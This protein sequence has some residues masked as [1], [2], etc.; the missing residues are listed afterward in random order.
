[1]NLR[2]AL[3]ILAATSIIFGA[4]FHVSA[5]AEKQTD[6]SVMNLIHKLPDVGRLPESCRVP[7]G[8]KPTVNGPAFP[9]DVSKDAK[10]ELKMKVQEYRKNIAE[11]GEQFHKLRS[12]LKPGTSV[13]DYPGLLAKGSIRYRT[14]TYTLQLGVYDKIRR[15]GSQGMFGPYLVVFDSKGMIR[16]VKAIIYSK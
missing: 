6:E 4:T 7:E 11:L 8:V 2:V 13:F 10:E 14:E 15:A 3:S 5:Q 9:P 1:M 12:H 16:E